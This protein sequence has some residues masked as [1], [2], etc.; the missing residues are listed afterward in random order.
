MIQQ[1][2]FLKKK[3]L[4][5]DSRLDAFEE[6]YINMVEETYNQDYDAPD[7]FI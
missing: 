2:K 5:R 6:K 3:T 1:S 4:H 7:F